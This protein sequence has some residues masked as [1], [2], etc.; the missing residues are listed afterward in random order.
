MFDA[1]ISVNEV[2]PASTPRA[3]SLSASP[4]ESWDADDPAN[5]RYGRHFLTTGK[6]HTGLATPGIQVSD[7]IAIILGGDVPVVLRRNS[8]YSG[9]SKAYHLLCECYIQAPSIMNGD[10]LLENRHL[11]E[12]IVLL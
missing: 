5:F 6:G 2:T 3:Q 7:S 12:D 10:F 4:S 1:I 9:K 11:A 8:D